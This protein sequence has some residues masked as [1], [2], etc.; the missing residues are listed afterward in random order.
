MQCPALLINFTNP[1]SKV[2]L[3]VTKL[4]R[5]R[6]VGICHGAFEGLNKISQVL[7]KSKENI[8]L[9]IGG[10][11][12]FYWVLKIQDRSNGKDLY[13]EF[14]QKMEQ[15]DC[16]LDALTREMF[17]LFNLF[18]YPSGS[19]IREYVSF[20]Y[21]IAG[22]IPLKWGIGEVARTI[23][24]GKSSSSYSAEIGSDEFNLELWSKW[25]I[26]KIEQAVEG[27]GSVI[28]ELAQPS[29]ELAVPI[30]CDIK[31]N[32][33]RKELS[34]N[35]PNDNFAVSNL[36]EDAV[37]E[38]SAKVDA[39]GIHPI[40][41]GPLPEVIAAICRNQISI[42]KLLVEAYRQRSKKLLLYALLLEPMVDNI[43][44]AKKM[45]EHLL[46]LEADYLPEFH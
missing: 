20:A 36:P 3:G 38:V 40:K 42:Q 17:K 28:E 10:L 14:R 1:E 15:S 24:S 27:K 2:C 25:Q 12:H 18:T 37:V 7:E 33:K 16:G 6:T 29:K 5:I 22:P 11:N 46:K 13:P 21:D 9:T 31:L 19:H 44:R 41:V 45:M 26:E 39:E 8:D 4:T 30:I 23:E 35:V 32:R 34:V 43:D